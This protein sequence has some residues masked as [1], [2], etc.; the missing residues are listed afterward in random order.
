MKTPLKILIV[1]ANYYPKITNKLIKSAEGV[2]NKNQILKQKTIIVPGIFEIPVVISQN[3]DKFDG[4][5]ALGCVI[6]GKTP[7]FDLITQAVTKAVMDL[8]IKYKK[9]IGNGII[10]SLNMKQAIERANP[11]KR[12]KGKEAAEA[13]IS[14]TDLTL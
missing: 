6:K 14:V 3:I 7:H 11:K 12:N 5:I 10:T 1:A 9:P 8:S 2:I 13:V 4:F